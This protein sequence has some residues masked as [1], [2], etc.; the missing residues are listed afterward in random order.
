MNGKTGDIANQSGEENI[1]NARVGIAR[2][3]EAGNDPQ[4]RQYAA[5]LLGQLRETEGIDPLIRALRDPEKKVRAQAVTALG[6]I[7]DPS[8][9]SLTLLMNDPDWKVR[10]R[11][12]EALGIIRSKKAVPFL[13]T[14]LDDQKD[15]VRYMAAKSLGMTGSGIAEQALIARLGDE[16]EFVRRSAA[17]ALGKSGGSAAVEALKNSLAR[18]PSEEVR[19]GIGSAL[20]L[21][22]K[23]VE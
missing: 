22:G 9:D 16:N 21:L 14:A 23:K 7:G 11:A 18:E 13:I 2:S 1:E 20:Q 8:V 17:T 4:V 15:H 5:M 19:N 6:E 12:A 10:Y 3:T